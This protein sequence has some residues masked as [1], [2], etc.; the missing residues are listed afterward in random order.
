M[1]FVI[2]SGLSG[3]G[4]TVALHTLEDLGAYCIDNLPVALISCVADETAKLAH[5]Y[6]LV[7]LGVDAR[8]ISERDIPQLLHTLDNSAV[9]Y[10]I[11]FLQAKDEVLIKR[12]SETR[13]R[14][15][16]SFGEIP[17]L[18]AIQC[19]RQLLAP[20][21]ARAHIHL[22]TSTTHLHQLRD[23]IHLQL[24][25]HH[26]RHMTLLFQSFGFKYGIPQDTDFVFDARCL[27]NPYWQPHLRTLSGR[28]A[29]VCHFLQTQPQVQHM[30]EDIKQFINTWIAHFEADNRC[31]LT[32]AV[33]CTGGH[34]RSVYLAEQLAADFSLRR[35]GVLVRHR[36]LHVSA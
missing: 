1:K 9:P 15:P 23:L 25:L 36:D 3:A 31:Y 34:H 29:E 10:Q 20:L 19:E 24:E 18:E 21:A 16:L 22:D 8:S 35:P 28:D 27:P 4:K 26:S 17:L 13:R 7:A 6:A 30:F 12:F 33:G 32:V 5:S 14:H 2:V 11:L